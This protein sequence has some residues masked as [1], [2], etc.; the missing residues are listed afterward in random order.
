MSNVAKR[1]RWLR[2]TSGV[3][4]QFTLQNQARQCDEYGGPKRLYLDGQIAPYEVVK[5]AIAA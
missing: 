1:K 4:M 3:V 2:H 5:N